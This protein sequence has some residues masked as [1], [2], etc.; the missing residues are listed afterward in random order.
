MCELIDI[1]DVKAILKKD[2]IDNL[3]VS[4]VLDASGMVI[5]LNPKVLVLPFVS[6]LDKTLGNQPDLYGS[7]TFIRF[8]PLSKKLIYFM[9]AENIDSVSFLEKQENSDSLNGSIFFVENASNYSFWKQCLVFE[10]KEEI[11]FCKKNN[12]K[13][14][15]FRKFFVNTSSYF[16]LIDGTIEGIGIN[17]KDFY[18]EKWNKYDFDFIKKYLWLISKECWFKKD[19]EENIKEVS[20]ILQDYKGKI[21]ADDID[22]L[23]EHFNL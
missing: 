11:V 10:E 9:Y 8:D 5:E 21:F 4:I 2:I 13:E 17:L 12:F 18:K 20:S 23:L 14:S 7:D 19:E 1:F 15:G 22:R 3:E 6:F 16:I